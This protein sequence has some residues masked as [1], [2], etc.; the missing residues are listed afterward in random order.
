MISFKQFLL[1]ESSSIE[2]LDIFIQSIVR[3]CGPFWK[4]MSHFYMR[5]QFIFRGISMFTDTS[6]FIVRDVRP[7]RV[8]KDTNP[9]FHDLLNDY[10][11][12]TTGIKFRSSSLFVTADESLAREFG[13]TF[14]IFPVGETTTCFSAVSPDIYADGFIADHSHDLIPNS[15]NRFKWTDAIL[16][17]KLKKYNLFGERD[18]NGERY[19]TLNM[20]WQRYLNPDL[21]R[22]MLTPDEILAIDNVPKFIENEIFPE[23]KYQKDNLA[24]AYA[25]AKG[26]IMLYCKKYYAI[27]FKPENDELNNALASIIA[28]LNAEYGIDPLY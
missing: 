7:D 4:E 3:D 11:E 19:K 18:I 13:S 20:L 27:K 15:K 16:I 10:L 21:D 14:I 25:N 22:S 24:N 9:L 12:K 23:L 6:N 8:P 1:N 5:N 28:A 26:E 2:D 17:D